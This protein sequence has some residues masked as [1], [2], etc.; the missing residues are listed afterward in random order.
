MSI[1]SPRAGR[2]IA[3]LARTSCFGL[4]LLFSACSDAGLFTP[5]PNG[6]VAVALRPYYAMINSSSNAAPVNRIRLT[7]TRQPG[8]QVIARQTLDVDPNHAAWNVDLELPA[9]SLVKVLIE[10]I[11]VTNGQETVEYSGLV[12]LQVTAGPQPTPAPVPVFPGPPAN[13]AV[14]SIAIAPRD[15][16]VLEG[17]NV[18]LTAAVGGTSSATVIWSS[19]NGSVATV[20]GNGRVTTRAPGQAVISAQAGAHSDNIT[21][22]VGARAERIVV[23]PANATLVSLGSDAAFTARVLDVRNA[24]VPGMSVTWS[25]GDAAIADQ[26]QPGV[27][28]ARRNGETTVTATTTQGMRVI[29]ATAPLKVE[30]R[31]ISLTIDPTRASFTALG[32]TQRFTVSAKDANGNDVAGVPFAWSSSNTAVATV[33]ANGTVTAR[34]N[35]T[36]TLRVQSGDAVATAEI[37]VEQQPARL[38]VTPTQLSFSFIGETAQVSAS[39]VDARD[40]VIDM[41]VRFFIAQNPAVATVEENGVVTAANNGHAVVIAEAGRLRAGVGVTV[42]QR[43][44]QIITNVSEVSVAGG[45]TFQ[46]TA[47]AV[48]A[49]ESPV[50]VPI[51]WSSANP[52]VAAVSST[53]LITGMTNGSTEI[54]AA[55]PGAEAR[56]R[57]N[58]SGGG[59][60][61]IAGRVVDSDGNAVA[62]A[63]IT[64]ATPSPQ[65]VMS[66]SDGRYESPLLPVGSWNVTAAKDGYVSTTYQNAAVRANQTVQLEQLVLVPSSTSTGSISGRVRSARTTAGIG[67]AVVELRAGQ[68]VTTGTPVATV[69]AT[70][71]GAYQFNNLPAQVYTV[72]A[73]ASGFTEGY[74]TGVVVGASLRTGQDVVLTPLGNPSEIYIVLTWGANPRD[75]DSHLTGPDGN[76]GRFHV[77]FGNSGTLAAPPFAQLDVDDTNG[78]GPETI[79]IS[80]TLTGGLYRY[81]VHHWSGTQSIATSGAL[82]RVYQGPTLLAQFTP[83]NQAGVIWTVFE[84]INGAI[85]PVN[86]IS[87]SAAFRRSPFDLTEAQRILNDIAAHPKKTAAPLR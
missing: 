5:K 17:D 71:T 68:N 65:S 22:T 4:L 46:A 49:G 62:G 42:Q 25:V 33:D 24:D 11:N 75:L 48:D 9:N 3:G 53:G 84:M 72:T 70:S 81:S 36:A 66:G 20:D 38:R 12:E 69:T 13:L 35:G 52:A 23:T 54:I 15:Q 44:T 79:T 1:H 59:L 58:V 77:Y 67:G 57:V 45:A 34:G 10:L 37:R 47:R 64:F 82:V 28:R 39:V 14:T 76:G 16:R 18:Q 73:R 83:P 56:I 87:S 78:F 29:S 21:I 31:A 61:R 30:Q 86:T 41:P 27:F 60:G 19:L 40:N 55:A 26:V 2:L 74:R 43:V 32:E 80:Q 51:T 85:T 6:F 63:T 7:V 50:N 8:D